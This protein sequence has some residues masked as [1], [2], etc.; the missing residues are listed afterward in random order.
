[1]IER[2]GDI[3]ESD[4]DWIVIPTNGERRSDGAAVMGAGLAKQAALKCHGVERVLGQALAKNG[5]HVQCLG[6]W[7]VEGV[8]R[9][10]IAFP[11]KNKWKEP[12]N[13]ELITRSAREL[14]GLLL[15]DADTIAMPR[16][17]TGCGGLGWGVVRYVL[18]R[19]LPG[20]RFIVVNR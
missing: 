10:L 18:E 4:A 7:V 1:M 19:E 3:W 20:E 13:L 17:G 15:G 9:C 5:N 14:Y 12:S 11:T 6:S 16:V 2:E 8:K